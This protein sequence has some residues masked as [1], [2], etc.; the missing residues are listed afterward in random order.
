[1]C[2]ILTRLEAAPILNYMVQ[3]PPGDGFAALADPTRRGILEQLGQE[4]ASISDLAAR[5]GITLT[6]VKKHVQVLEDAGLVTTEKVGR[7]R[8]CRLGPNQ[9]AEETM[10][11]ERYRQKL[12]GRLDRL[13][14]FLD[15]AK[16]EGS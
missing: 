3:Y 9:L 14:E 8:H 13:S 6:G 2:Q 10:W 15:R 12:G 1:L 7:V 11:I 5:F 4:D 16:G